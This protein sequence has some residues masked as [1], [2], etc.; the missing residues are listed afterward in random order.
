MNVFMLTS[1]VRSLVD[2]VNKLLTFCSTA[3]PGVKECDGALR[4]LEVSYVYMCCY[5]RHLYLHVLP[6]L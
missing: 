3:R 4:E 1:T 2:E 5:T 6:K